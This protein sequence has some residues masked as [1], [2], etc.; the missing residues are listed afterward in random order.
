MCQAHHERTS[1][2]GPS[3]DVFAQAN[4]KPHSNPS[5]EPSTHEA[6][7]CLCKHLSGQFILVKCNSMSVVM[8]LNKMGGVR[9]Q[10]LCLQTVCL[11]LWCSCHGISVQAAN[12]PGVDNT[13]VDR[14]SRRGTAIKGPTKTRSL[15]VD[16]H[17]N[18]TAYLSL[19]NKVG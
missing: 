19:F 12:L 1:S 15:S 6:L 16:W 10:S 8:Y 7:R 17:L 11:L 18:K 3:L 9:S 14:L 13:F 5:S 4:S 2:N